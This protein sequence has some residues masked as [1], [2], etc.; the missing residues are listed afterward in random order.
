MRRRARQTT[1]F[2]EPDLPITPMLD[3]SFQLLAFFIMTFKP[4]PTEG[5]IAM[6]LPP[7]E[8]GGGAG[9]PMLGEEKPTK[10]I[11]RVTATEG[12]NIDK[13]T[14][15]EDGSP[16]AVG[17]DLGASPEAFLAEASRL[18]NSEQKRMNDARSQG[19][20]IPPPKL[21]L[22]FDNKL[23]QANIVQL[24]DGGVQA[25]FTDIAPVPIGKR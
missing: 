25:G 7:P 20:N 10:W 21:L 14:I 9:I 1:D 13:I 3:M 5:Q 4:A 23:I 16:D 24:I 6:S 18:W 17:K 11:V 12:G 15:R 8:Q 19:R 22:E 2:V